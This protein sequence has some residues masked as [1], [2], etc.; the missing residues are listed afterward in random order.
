MGLNFSYFS[1]IQKIEIW[2]IEMMLFLLI[3]SII[4]I[5]DTE[6]GQTGS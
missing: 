3:K 4:Q 1:E 5:S 2:V 6:A